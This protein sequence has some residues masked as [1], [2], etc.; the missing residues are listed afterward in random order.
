MLF[1]V[2]ASCAL[3]CNLM[4]W[5]NTL[6]LH[7]SRDDGGVVEA[8]TGTVTVGDTTVDFD[9]AVVADG[10][11]CTDADVVISFQGDG[12]DVDY[13]V[14]MPM[15]VAAGNTTPDWNTSEPNG[16]GCGERYDGELDVLLLATP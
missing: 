11:S 7:V 12:A 8:P 4:G 1:L 16:K 5:T 2:L 14:H 15:W 10:Y 9:C 6:T 3:E 13:E